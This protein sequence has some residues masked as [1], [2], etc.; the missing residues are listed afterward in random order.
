MGWPAK[1]KNDWLA[2]EDN[3]QEDYLNTVHY[4]GVWPVLKKSD[5]LSETVLIVD[6]GKW[7]LWWWTNLASQGCLGSSLFIA[8]QTNHM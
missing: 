1:K 4:W 7:D 2:F 6:E 3:D 5:Y 8:G